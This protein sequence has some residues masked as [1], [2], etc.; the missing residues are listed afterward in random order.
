MSAYLS[1]CIPTSSASDR[2]ELLR[3]Q[4]LSLSAQDCAPDLFD[5]IVAVDGP[6]PDGVVQALV[7]ELAPTC[8]HDVMVVDSPRPEGAKLPHRNHARNAAWRASTA[9]WCWIMDGDFILPPHAITHALAELTAATHRGLPA[10]LTPCMGGITGT[11]SKWIR[12]SSSWVKGKQTWADLVG[13]FDEFEPV[14]SG[15]LDRYQPGPPASVRVSDLPEGMPIIPRAILKALGGFDEYF[16]GWGGN[17]EEII[18][19]LKG[20]QREGVLDIRLLASVRILH[21]PHRKDKGRT[22]GQNEKQ[23]R[24]EQKA[25]EIK[26]EAD[27]WLEQLGIVSGVDLP[28]LAVPQCPTGGVQVVISTFN[29]PGQLL[30]LLL[31]LARESEATSTQ[32]GVQVYDDASTADMLVVRRFLAEKGWLYVRADTNHGKR[33]YC[34]WR[35]LQMAAQRLE[36]PRLWVY[37]DDDMRLCDRF[38]ERLD[39]A[40]ASAPEEDRATLVLHIDSARNSPDTTCWTGHTPV[41]RGPVDEISWVDGAFAADRVFHEAMEWTCPEPPADRWD[42]DPSLSC[43][44]GM[45]L[46]RALDGA[47]LHQYRVKGSLV[48]HLYGESMMNPEARAKVDLITINHVDGDDRCWQLA[49]HLACPVIA[50]MAAIPRRAESLREVVRRLEGQVDHL[51]ICLN[52]WDEAPEWLDRPWI[53]VRLEDNTLGDAGK[54]LWV[55]DLLSEAYYADR[56][57]RL[58]WKFR[59][60][61][62]AYHLLVDDDIEYPQLYA[63]VL[64]ARIENYQRQAVLGFHGAVLHGDVGSYYQDRTVRHMTEASDADTPVHVLGTGVMAYHTSTL[65]LRL[66]MF[67]QPNMADLFVALAARDQGVPMVALAREEGEF[68]IIKD[69]AG[70]IYDQA[71]QAGDEAQTAVIM[72]A[73]PWGDPLP[74]PKCSAVVGAMPQVGALEDAQAQALAKCIESIEFVRLRRRHGP[75]LALGAWAQVAVEMLGSKDIEARIVDSSTIANLPAD[76]ASD[77]LLAGGVE[78]MTDAELAPLLQEVRRVLRPR[79]YVAIVAQT[80]I[81]GQRRCHLRNTGT[82]QANVPGLGLLGRFKGWTVLGGKVG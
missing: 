73:G 26:A 57:E 54:M 1:V 33:G 74:L 7:A 12:A 78:E 64:A 76:D 70:S 51:N 3:R 62:G 41:G 60:G 79:G 40:W 66:E 23:A 10:V 20:L 36:S 69:P 2:V 44:V 63:S 34:R 35:G 81:P 65:A 49:H 9:L 46:S 45:M 72:S 18:D 80:Q 77:L 75:V 37:F 14:H 42:Q 21:Q 61:Q 17:K 53:T 67:T 38:F 16:T 48:V 58:L 82:Y 24:R 50:S 43:G 71:V 13:K 55:E 47:G 29:R 5:V 11:P 39:E 8:R 25:A 32:I 68:Q 27:W 4:L 31:D 59:Q 19:R 30:D 28:A 15:F 52:G 6:D 56:S 22:K